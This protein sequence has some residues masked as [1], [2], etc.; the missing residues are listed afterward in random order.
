MVTSQLIIQG[1]EELK[2]IESMKGEIASENGLSGLLNRIFDGLGDIEAAEIKVYREFILVGKRIRGHGS[3]YSYK[4]V[5][6]GLAKRSD[7]LYFAIKS[8]DGGSLP[9]YCYDAIAGDVNALR[10]TTVH[11]ARAL[12]AK[13]ARL[14]EKGKDKKLIEYYESERDKVLKRLEKDD[15]DFLE[16]S[17]P[18]LIEIPRNVDIFYDEDDVMISGDDGIAVEN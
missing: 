1:S 15:E 9:N 16:L 4:F 12:D 18:I 7:G 17:E 2:K 8:I 5:N 3:R 13:I 6:Y 11:Y 10:K 14:K